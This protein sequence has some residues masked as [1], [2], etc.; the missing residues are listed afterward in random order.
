M[1][2]MVVQLGCGISRNERKNVMKERESL[3]PDRK[4]FRENGRE[5]EKIKDSIH[6]G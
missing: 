5:R 3:R 4:S 2:I 1:E 6:C